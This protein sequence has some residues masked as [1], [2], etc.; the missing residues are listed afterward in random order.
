MA[1]G[2]FSINRKLFWSLGG[3]DPEMRL[4]GGE[5]VE[6]SF[7][8]WQCH[9]SLEAIP[10]ARVAHIFRSHEYW[11]GAVFS[12]GFERQRNLLRT[13]EVW[14]DEYKDMAKKNIGSLP[15]SMSLG[16]LD[17]MLEVRSRL[18]CKPFKWLLE[19]V[20]PELFIPNDPRSIKK[21][22]YI[23]YIYIC[24]YIYSCRYKYVE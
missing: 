12:V 21:G 20:F 14:M 8:L 19:E 24:I 18:Q 3:Y 16:P 13:I 11:H 4:Y 10:C 5:E 15:P 23:I 9:C 17:H 2:L 1:G 7:R 22:Y 6:I